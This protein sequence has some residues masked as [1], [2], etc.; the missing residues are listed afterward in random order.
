MSGEAE[1]VKVALVEALRKE[2]GVATAERL[3]YAYHRLKERFRNVE[4]LL[5]FVEENLAGEVEV[6]EHRHYPYRDDVERVVLLR[7]KNPQKGK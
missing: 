2:E 1:R 7:L 6:R 4:E 5:E 3:L